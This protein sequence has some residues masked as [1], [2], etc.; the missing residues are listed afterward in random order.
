MSDPNIVLYPIARIVRDYLIA[1]S[2][3]SAYSTTTDWAIATA[4]RPKLPLNVITI[5]E[6]TSIVRARYHRGGMQDDLVVMI[7]VRSTAAEPGEYRAKLIM[8]AMDALARWEWVGDSDEYG[9]TV[10]IATAKRQRGIFPLGRDD[11]KRHIF[12]L[13]YALVIQSITE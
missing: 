11:N 5:Y 7:E 4:E 12:N 6:E 10:L 8:K 3:G 9:Q 1:Q 13:E 2:V